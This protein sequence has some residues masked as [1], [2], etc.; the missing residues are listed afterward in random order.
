MKGINI[1]WRNPS[2]LICMAIVA[3][4]FGALG[5]MGGLYIDLVFGILLS[6]VP[7][8]PNAAALSGGIVGAAIGAWFERDCPLVNSNDGTVQDSPDPKDR[9]RLDE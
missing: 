8:E 2:P 9:W 7:I 4:V 1:S 6:G 5:L 3:S